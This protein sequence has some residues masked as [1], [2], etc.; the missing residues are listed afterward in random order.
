MISINVEFIRNEE[1]N[2]ECFDSFTMV[3]TFFKFL[4]YWGVFLFQVILIKIK[5]LINK[6][7]K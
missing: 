2:K 1:E 3:Y 4:L 6:F 7:L 5:Q